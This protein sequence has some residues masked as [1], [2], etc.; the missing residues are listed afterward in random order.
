MAAR[1]T[2]SADAGPSATERQAPSEIARLA[3]EESAVAQAALSFTMRCHVGQRRVSDGEPFIAH[4]LEV[5]RL[6]RDAGCSGVLVAAGLLHDVMEDAS[7]GVE[8]LKARFGADVAGL[9]EAVSDASLGSYRE[10]KHAQ[11]ERVRRAG[12][13]AALLFAAD[14]IATVRGLRRHVMRDRARFDASPRHT[15]ARDR[16]EQ[17]HRWRLEH[18]RDSLGMLER[19]APRH[20]LVRRLADELDHV[21]TVVVAHSAA[22]P[23][24]SR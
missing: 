8:E 18:Y 19:I 22:E 1:Y 23:Q 9:I 2:G 4:R 14:K 17:H 3:E 20:S 21:A 5:A 24:R 6:L 7:V 12:T 16:M 10:R 15:R 13:D 11:R